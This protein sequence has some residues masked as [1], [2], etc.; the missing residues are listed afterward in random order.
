MTM[1]IN[2][3]HMMMLTAAGVGV[4][5]LG[6]TNAVWAQDGAVLAY[7][8]S[9]SFVTF[10]PWAQV[11]TQS[12]T[13]N[14][15]FSRL[16][17]SDLDG[18]LVGDLAETWAFSD[19]GKAITLK[20]R[21]G[22]LWHDGKALVAD[23]FVTMYSYLSDPTYEGDQGVG[24]IKSL[25]APV[26][27]VEAPD[28][29]TVVISFSAPVPYATAILGYFYAIRFDSAEDTVM[30]QNGPVG[31]G[32]FKFGEHVAGQYATFTRNEEYFGDQ[33]K[34]D[35]FR[36]SLYAQGS[37]VSPNLTAGEVNGILVANQAEVEALRANPDFSVMQ[38][39]VGAHVLMVNASKP[40]F[41]NPLV[42]QALSYSMNREAFSEAA[43]FGLEVPT[44]SPFYDANS[45]GYAEELV[46]A[47]A[48]DLDR[49]AALLAEAGVS[50]LKLT[51]PAPNS[52]P[53]YGTYGEIWQSDLAAIGVDL[54]IERVDAA[55]WRD[56]GAGKVPEIDF[57]PWTVGRSL[58][59]P[60]IF[61][62]ANSLYRAVNQR[63]GYVN[64]AFEELLV[65][66]AVEIDPAKR[67]ELFLQIGHVLLDE[68]WN[69]AMLSD[70]KVYVWDKKFEGQTADRGGNV[71]FG[72]IAQVG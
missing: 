34:L 47:H 16:V 19:D 68:S 13:A 21:P 72:N 60:S 53:N 18:N 31:T 36:F 66:A 26:T 49:A 11:L 67:R 52:N 41:D 25:F 17:Y 51:Y 70:T 64:P 24:K 56:M 1:T 32:P 39:P 30:L 33:A 22:V 54:Q 57:V 46:N 12:S 48:F 45:I 6:G 29:S 20:L 9:G 69:I 43:H 61:F 71:S 35:G 44:A 14:Q 23:D 15:V 8:E 38:V 28:A 55:R 3:R 65:S 59:D 4:A 37:N 63:F 10:N 58:I 7:G 5:A 27:A 62:A 2:R 50:D 42:R 40:P